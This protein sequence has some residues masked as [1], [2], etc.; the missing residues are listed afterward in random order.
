MKIGKTNRH[1][2]LIYREPEVIFN[3][4]TEFDHFKYW[5]P[6]EQMTVERVTFGEFRIGTTFHFKLRYR[7]EPEWDSEVILIERPYRIAYRFLNGIFEGGREIWDLKKNESGTEVTHTLIY[8]I[9]R[10][11]YKIGWTFL[12]GERK[13]N[14]LTE[15]ALK[16]LKSYV[17]GAPR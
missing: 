9:H 7:I 10:W 1:H 12:G 14:E 4:L 2:I 13:H 16:R 15:T 11:I 17:E 5:I 8:Q 3:I 6:L